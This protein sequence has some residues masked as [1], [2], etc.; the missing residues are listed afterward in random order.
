MR[1]A[2]LRRDKNKM[3]DLCHRTKKGILNSFLL[4]LNI[5]KLFFL[6]PLGYGTISDKIYNYFYKHARIHR[7]KSVLKCSAVTRRCLGI[8]I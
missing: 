8:L 7:Q 1:L 6:T 2:K 5:Q 3:T 4:N